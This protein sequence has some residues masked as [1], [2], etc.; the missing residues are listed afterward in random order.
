MPAEYQQW[1]VDKQWPVDEQWP[2]VLLL[3]LF[4]PLRQMVDVLG[5]RPR[6]RS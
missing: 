4:P 5:P 2:V 3:V 6:R 1:P